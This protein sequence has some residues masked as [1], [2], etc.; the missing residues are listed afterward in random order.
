MP[1]I[2]ILA[3]V[4]PTASGKTALGIDLAR[5]LESEI[6]SVD[7]MQVYRHMNIGTAKPTPKELK[8]A[9]HHMI[10]IREPDDPINAG[11]FCQIAAGIIQKLHQQGKVPVLVGGT[12]LYL[13][14]LVHGL[15]DVPD[16]PAEIHD[17]VWALWREKGVKSCH[18]K[19]AELDP[20]SG[21]K[22]HPND[23][24]RIL[25]ALEVKLATGKS[26]QAFQNAHRFEEELYQVQYVALDWNREVLY[27]R[28][29]QR[30][31]QMVELGLIEE[32][33]EL[34]EKGFPK[35]LPALNS[36]GYQQAV[37][38]LTGNMSL[39]EMIA[40]IQQK[41]RRYAKKQLTWNRKNEDILYLQPDYTRS[42]LE[43][44]ITAFSLKS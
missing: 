17:E 6:I 10:D 5:H 28:I 12:G 21:N 32:T 31:L 29:N 13:R 40:D 41:T 3:V 37:K 23:V 44:F 43:D 22:L 38:Y 24:S 14:A 27:E 8:A 1:Q 34:L 36:I 33:R 39:D 42:D 4:G 19:L 15:I 30:V 11:E 7:S 9:V 20:E 16:I 25:R 35:E 18:Q 26:I 2:P